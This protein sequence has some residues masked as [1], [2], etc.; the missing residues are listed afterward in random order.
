MRKL[1]LILCSILLVSA[2]VSSCSRAPEYVGTWEGEVLVVTAR[3]IL[4][5]D[6]FVSETFS[7]NNI[8]I[9]GKKGF[10]SVNGDIMKMIVTDS[11]NFDTITNSGSWEKARETYS[12]KFKVTDDTILLSPENSEFSMT[13]LRQ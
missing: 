4:E 3:Y 10:Y 12:M 6:T 13:L 8:L 2:F 5:M 7:F 11:Y 1:F 9:Q